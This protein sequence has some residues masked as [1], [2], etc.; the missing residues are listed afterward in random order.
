VTAPRVAYVALGSNLDD[1]R[2]QVVRAFSELDAV[3]GTRVTGRSS[4]YRNPAVGEPGQ[5]D[6]V[7]AVAR[8]ET[9]LGARDLLDALLAIEVAHG[10]GR[11]ESRWGPR[12]LDLDLVVFGDARIDEPGL[13]VPHPG[14]TGRAFVLYPLAELAPDLEIPGAGP[15]HT[16]IKR[17]P[18]DGLAVLED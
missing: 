12:T 7:N 5:P 17:V 13:T 3:P 2:A 6:F 11:G 4:L 9:T 15:I 10:R 16:L 1:P 14:L 8:V 18:G